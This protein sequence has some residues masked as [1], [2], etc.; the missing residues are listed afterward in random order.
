[1]DDAPAG[2]AWALTGAGTRLDGRCVAS[3]AQCER[4]RLE[5]APEG[6]L[7]VGEEVALA[8]ESAAFGYER[9]AQLERWSPRSRRG[10]GWLAYQH[11]RADDTKALQVGDGVVVGE[12]DLAGLAQ[13]VVVYL[14]V[15]GVLER[16][17]TRE[18]ARVDHS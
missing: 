6:D 5:M 3:V 2:S 17:T 1:M 11:L 13:R 18:S 8:E 15:P 16:Q 4:R 9:G 7:E 10:R 12:D 14:Q